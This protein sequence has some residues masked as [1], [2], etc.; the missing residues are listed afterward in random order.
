MS[1]GACAN[2]DGNNDVRRDVCIQE[3]QWGFVGCIGVN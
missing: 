1:V 2:D 3:R